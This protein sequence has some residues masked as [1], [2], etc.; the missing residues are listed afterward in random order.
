[1]WGS[2][3]QSLAWLLALVAT[4]ML[5]ITAG[6]DERSLW[7]TTGI[8]A[9][10][11][12]LVLGLHW[13]LRTSGLSDRTVGARLTWVLSLAL[14]PW[15]LELAIRMVLE[16]MWPLELVLLAAFR[17][18]VL[19]LA[20]FAHETP[21]QR[22]GC[23]LS[24]FLVIFASALAV[25]FWA[26]GMVILFALLGVWWLMG[27]YWETLRGRLAASS[28]QG[29]PRKWAILLPL[30]VLLCLTTLPVAGT[31]VRV[32]R[33][34][35]PSSGGTDQ[36]SEAARS[37]VGDGD[38]LV[39]GT[40]DIR[41][42]API[43]D[44]PFLASHEPSLYDLF[45]D[46]YNEPVKVERQERAIAIERELV[47][48]QQEH[49]LAQ[50]QIA[51][52]QFSTVR[53]M[54]ERSRAK[55]GDR[56][57][58]AVLYVSGRVPVHLKLQVFN[59]YD[60]IEW[61][62]QPL[63]NRESRLKMETLHGR[64]WLRLP[65]APGP[66]IY[67]RAE[68]HA[69]KIARLDSN[70]IPSP[71]Q[72]LGIHLDKLD[73]VDMF[74]WA[75]P[76]IVRMDREKLP[77]QAVIHVQSRVVDHRRFNP[78]I[79]SFNGRSV[80]YQQFGDDPQSLAVRQLAQ[81]WTRGVDGD[82]PQVNAI[83]ERLRR[84]YVLDREARPPED[85][86]HTVAD[87]LFRAKR[88]PD[89]QFASAAVY[90][91][92]SLGHSAR[93]VSGFY[94][95]DRHY[96][97][98]S[99]H[100]SVAADDIHFWAEVNAGA[101][102]WIP[103]EPTPGYELLQPPPTLWH[104]LEDAA[105]VA[106][107]CVRRHP[108]GTTALVLLVGSIF[109]CRHPLRDA[110]ATFCWKWT[111]TVEPRHYVLRTAALL[112]RRFGRAGMTRPAGQTPARWLRA[113]AR[114]SVMADDPPLDELTTLFDWAGYAPAEVACPAGD[115]IALCRRAEQAWSWRRLTQFVQVERKSRRLQRQAR[116]LSKIPLPILQT[117]QG[118]G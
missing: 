58:R 38:A 25:D 52:K 102:H 28:E 60:G 20:V 16:A 111:S 112:D 66:D 87:F 75:Q 42:F 81:E 65:I 23:V 104:R 90:M 55:I 98:R 31:Q 114:K 68:T 51:G 93:L 99:R 19:A 46:S 92:R 57:S 95:D 37:G 26:Q 6:S 88:G 44:A 41:S 83:V 15:G 39:A 63:A 115:P 105:W 8:I 2:A 106:V 29:L 11:T 110:W 94:A 96:D 53:R 33:G 13:S 50:S 103:I 69:L 12:L 74:E 72:L 32:L 24:T 22:V 27:S 49:H 18:T 61:Y 47:H 67:G 71:T 118:I 86:P 4:G 30:L 85:C 78:E 5:E 48:Q 108:L 64:P 76:G 70:R 79:L 117:A 56:K 40:D 17:N 73:Q 101:E 9:V 21:S 54:G 7:T 43:E 35:M 97:S 36:F 107:A 3:S 116:S 82:W 59:L 62:P 84:E 80:V 14:I 10:E 113:L 1:M 91:V 100:T 89:Y 109:V 45:D 34:F 77:S